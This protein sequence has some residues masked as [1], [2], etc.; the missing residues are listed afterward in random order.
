MITQE[1]V[2]G[3]MRKR[4]IAILDSRELSKVS[5]TAASYAV[6]AASMGLNDLRS[7]TEK[8]REIVNEFLVQPRVYAKIALQVYNADGIAKLA[9]QLS[10]I[11][12][13]KE[14]VMSPEVLAEAEKL[15]DETVLQY[16]PEKF[17][18]PGNIQG[19]PG[20]CKFC[21]E[22]HGEDTPAEERQAG[23]LK[24]INELVN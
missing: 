11:G 13:P 6:V 20:A 14:L 3:D 22:V 5:I 2:Q 9:E 1:Q 7:A 17:G 19:K 12:V 4:I 10:R 15:A 23:N 24:P 8:V 16:I 18:N 21:G